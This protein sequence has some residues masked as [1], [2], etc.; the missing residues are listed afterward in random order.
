MNVAVSL[1]VPQDL[2]DVATLVELKVLSDLFIP[3]VPSC[4]SGKGNYPSAN[5]STIQGRVVQ[6]PIK[7]ILG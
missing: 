6:S 3:R 7:L 4:R 1:L 5:D 2:A